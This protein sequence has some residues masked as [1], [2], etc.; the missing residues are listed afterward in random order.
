MVMAK[1][2][3]FLAW[4]NTESEHNKRNCQF[5]GCD[6]VKSKVLQVE[7]VCK[8]IECREKGKTSERQDMG[9]KYKMHFHYFLLNILSAF[10]GIFGK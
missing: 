4:N 5:K 1:Y 9:V 7:Q 3:I 10:N 2:Q 6:F 8:I